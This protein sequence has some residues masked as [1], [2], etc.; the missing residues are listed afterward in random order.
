M[1]YSEPYHI[2]WIAFLSMPQIHASMF[3]FILWNTAYKLTMSIHDLLGLL[4]LFWMLLVT[5][6]FYLS[7]CQLFDSFQIDFLLL[8]DFVAD[9]HY[10]KV[11]LIV[12][13]CIEF[14][15][16]QLHEKPPN[17][18]IRYFLKHIVAVHTVSHSPS[19]SR[20]FCLII[21]V[22][23]IPLN[24]WV[25]IVICTQPLCWHC[26]IKIPYNQLHLSLVGL[27]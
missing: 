22:I 19:T 6:W 15:V 27:D 7:H 9:H 14:V 3:H 8:L 13:Q 24:S 18:I 10:I 5:L 12:S 21:D 16:S 4:I 11:L 23:Q 25:Y 26:V 17:F 20:T 1:P 2:A